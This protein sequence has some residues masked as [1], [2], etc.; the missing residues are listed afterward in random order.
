MLFSFK[1]RRHHLIENRHRI[2]RIVVP[3]RQVCEE[4]ALIAGMAGRSDLNDLC[5]NRIFI[6]VDIQRFY[7]LAVTGSLT[8][9][10]E[11]PAAPA[12]VGHPSAA[13]RFIK[14]LFIHVSDHQ[15]FSGLVFLSDHRNQ[16]AAVQFEFTERNG[17]FKTV[18]RYIVSGKVHL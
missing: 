2:D 7:I 9:F 12:P 4:T 1:D 5:Q 17:A 18:G 15:H 11:F 3:C 14:S 10:P 6:T 13:D 16:S 8:L